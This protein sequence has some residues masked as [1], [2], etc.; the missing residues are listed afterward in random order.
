M[1][2]LGLVAALLG[3]AADTAETVPLGDGGAAGE[4]SCAPG[5]KPVEGGCLEAGVDP[6]RCA[7]GFESDDEGG[8]V[9]LL[10]ADSCPPGTMA[11]LGEQHCHPVSDCGSDTWGNIVDEPDTQ[12]VD[13]RYTGD[14]SDGSR[15][16]PWNRIEDALAAASPGATVALA[17][18]SYSGFIGII[19][20]PVEIRGRCP[21]RVAII[22]DDFGI[23]VGDPNG[24]ADVDGTAI[25]D[26]AVTGNGL[27]IIAS[28]VRDLALERLWIHDLGEGAV[29][30]GD[31]WGASS[32]VLSDSLIERF[33]GLGV[34]LM[35]SEVQIA[36]TVVRE[37][38][39]GGLGDGRGIGFELFDQPGAALVR[40]SIIE[41][42]QGVGLGVVGRPVTAEV[43]V[44]RD[45]RPMVDGSQG[46][47]IGVGDHPAGARG[48]LTLRQSFVAENHGQGILVEG[49]SAVVEHTVLRN[50][51][52]GAG[53]WV[54][55]GL[56]SLSA[57]DLS[58]TG[59]LVTSNHT[60]GIAAVGAHATI[61]S[62]LVRDTSTN[63]A[64][65]LGLGIYI[66]LD[67][68]LP[69]GASPI[70]GGEIRWS[71]VEQSHVAGLS[72]VGA[73]VTVADTHILDSRTNDPGSFGDGVSAL[74]TG[75][76]LTTIVLDRNRI[77]ASGRAGIANFTALVKLSNTTLECNTI[78]LDGENS[79]S[80]S[81]A[82]ED[83]GGNLCGCDG[84]PVVCKILESSLQPPAQ[85]GH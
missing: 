49:S 84:E 56:D 3:C 39:S 68:A 58:L 7:P 70:G 53:A 11:L 34:G 57:A 2:R 21:D 33:H 13:A 22:A 51:T 30:V 45:T 63:A 43:I 19:D 47:G 66:G 75:P 73:E 44:I 65:Q 28:N 40:D 15:S 18:G 38:E 48:E 31:N 4:A 55:Y 41:N 60:A 25:R 59:C 35:S 37:G 10:P 67:A 17:E 72:V 27:G 24:V 85:V 71:R 50:T 12:Y 36:R 64:G 26:L 23:V 76:V 54:Q 29:L 9:P 77:E 20:K 81:Y 78:H 79:P 6:E 46:L 52:L 83:G 8:C 14:D 16:R 74:A 42:N 32:V 69:L 1:H 5:S 61:E 80:G 82:F 62:T